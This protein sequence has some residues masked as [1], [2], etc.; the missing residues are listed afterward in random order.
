MFD[1]TLTSINDRFGGFFMDRNGDLK[2]F[3]V[4]V[5]RQFNSLDEVELTMEKEML[6]ADLHSL[7]WLTAIRRCGTQPRLWQ[8]PPSG[9]LRTTQALWSS[10]HL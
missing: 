5:F 1:L 8:Y 9:L 7:G 3:E 4:T 10:L 2:N 6:L